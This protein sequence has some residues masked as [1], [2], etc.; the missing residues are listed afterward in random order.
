M[1]SHGKE[2]LIH[3]GVPEAK[4]DEKN[5]LRCEHC[6]QLT[7]DEWD[8]E[9]FH[10]GCRLRAAFPDCYETDGDT[11]KFDFEK[12]KAHLDKGS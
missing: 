8:L 7:D 5:E 2:E 9:I 4:M 3:L 12:I 10:R 6:G 11:L 1:P